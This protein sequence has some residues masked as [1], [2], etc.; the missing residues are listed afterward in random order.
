MNTLLW[1]SQGLVAAIFLM[2]GMT[3]LTQPR[4]KIK[5]KVGD[6][7]DVVSDSNL[8]LIGLL[9]MFGAIGLVLPMLLNI[10]PVLTPIAAVGLSITMVS[11]MSLH[12]KRKE[13]DKLV[14]N[15]V[16]LVLSLFIAIGRFI[17]VP[18]I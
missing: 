4:E 10:L 18:V 1:I 15:V 7:V 5:E 2:A 3:K 9:E 11:A 14:P 6:W 17:I 13:M 8:K 16:L 12:I